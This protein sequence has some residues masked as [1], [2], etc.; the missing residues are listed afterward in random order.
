MSE[1]NTDANTVARP[2]KVLLTR[3]QAR[4][5]RAEYA[6]GQSK[7]AALATKYG[8]TQGRISQIIKKSKEMSNG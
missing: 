2:K 6:T 7:Q 3:E 5:I 4:E 8:I 1:V